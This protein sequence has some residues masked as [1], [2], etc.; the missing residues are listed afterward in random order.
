MMADFLI[1]LL[2]GESKQNKKGFIPT[3]EMS[4]SIVITSLYYMKEVREILYN[5]YS[6][7]YYPIDDYS[8]LEIPF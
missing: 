8:S 5:L 2:I 1:R 3:C 6:K 4:S 7:D